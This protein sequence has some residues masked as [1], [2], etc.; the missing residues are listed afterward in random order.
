MET[1]DAGDSRI[2]KLRNWRRC[3]RNVLLT[4]YTVTIRI[5]R[6]PALSKLLSW[7][8]ARKQFFFRFRIPSKRFL[9]EKKRI[10]RHKIYMKCAILGWNDANQEWLISAYKKKERKKAIEGTRREWRRRKFH[11]RAVRSPLPSELSPLTVLCSLNRNIES[12]AIRVPR[13]HARFHSLRSFH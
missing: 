9:P 1:N 8:K 2:T 6:F 3:S 11:L 5:R 7:E 10:T 13:F 4:C 12:R